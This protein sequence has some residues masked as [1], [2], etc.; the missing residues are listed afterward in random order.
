MMETAAALNLYE[1]LHLLDW[2]IYFPKLM[3]IFQQRKQHAR[4]SLN[5]DKSC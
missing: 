3:T 4:R 5:A 1:S 2:F